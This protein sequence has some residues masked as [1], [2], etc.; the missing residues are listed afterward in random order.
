[1][2]KK[3]KRC[4]RRGRPKRRRH[5]RNGK[6]KQET[7]PTNDKE[8]TIDIHPNTATVGCVMALKLP[9]FLLLSVISYAFPYN[10]WPVEHCSTI[11]KLYPMSLPYYSW[12]EIV[13]SDVAETIL[14]SLTNTQLLKILRIE[15]TP[16]LHLD[17]MYRVIEKRGIYRVFEPMVGDAKP[18]VDNDTILV[19]LKIKGEQNNDHEYWDGHMSSVGFQTHCREIPLYPIVTVQEYRNNPE[20]NYN[21]YQMLLYV[22]SGIHEDFLKRLVIFLYARVYSNYRP[23]RY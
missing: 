21:E 3:V 16:A 23:H 12:H 13:N 8:K 14:C 4:I 5:P 20:H 1:M 15:Y 6:K 9:L 19:F 11:L 22:R 2:P 18:N 10:L 7:R 17:K